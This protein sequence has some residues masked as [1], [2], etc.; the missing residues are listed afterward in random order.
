MQFLT[1]TTIFRQ[2]LFTIMSAIRLHQPVAF[3]Y[4]TKLL[5]QKD[6]DLLINELSA[7]Y[8]KYYNVTVFNEFIPGFLTNINGRPQFHKKINYTLVV[9]LNYNPRSARQVSLLN[10]FIKLKFE[11]II[12]SPYEIDLVAFVPF[13]YINFDLNNKS[14]LKLF[15]VYLF[16]YLEL[17]IDKD[18][19]RLKGDISI[20]TLYNYNCF[21]C[22]ALLKKPNILK[23]HLETHITS[24]TDILTP[25]A[26]AL[27]LLKNTP[28]KTEFLTYYYNKQNIPILN[29]YH[30]KLKKK[31]VKKLI[32]LFKFLQKKYK[33]KIKEYKKKRKEYKDKVIQ[34]YK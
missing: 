22:L 1:L 33:K 23:N 34:K 13:M 30:E 15:N 14:L 17:Y 12:I 6:S 4:D 31:F 8:E 27:I 32:K 3:Y 2:F 24:I 20:Q 25:N 28:I 10:E 11:Y 9:F 29:Q 21:Y 16:N 18:Q 5:S 19:L 26:L 7:E